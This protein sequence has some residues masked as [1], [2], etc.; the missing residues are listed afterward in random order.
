MDVS[1]IVLFTTV[2]PVLYGTKLHLLKK[3]ASVQ[4]TVNTCE[5]SG[6]NRGAVEAIRLPA[7]HAALVGD[8]G[9][10]QPRAVPWKNKGLSVTLLARLLCCCALSFKFVGVCKKNTANA[11]V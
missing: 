7:H 5:I 8:F 2:F 11:S 4:Q 10:N 1:Q 9:T 6:V 3:L